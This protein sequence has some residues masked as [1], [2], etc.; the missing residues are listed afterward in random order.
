MSAGRTRRHERQ[1]AG[2]DGVTAM[3]GISVIVEGN[4]AQSCLDPIATQVRR[5]PARTPRRTPGPPPRRRRTHHA[6]SRRSTRRSRTRRRGDATAA[7]PQ[8]RATAATRSGLHG[9]PAIPPSTRIATRPRVSWTAPAS[10]GG[11]AVWADEPLRFPHCPG[12][13][14]AQ[15]AVARTT[16]RRPA[17]ISS[18]SPTVRDQHASRSARQQQTERGSS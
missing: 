12:R 11:A 18:G 10:D 1:T 15:A 9:S 16:S 7:T 4:R 17:S 14:R 2:A 8:R 6:G 13:S 5:R 3:R